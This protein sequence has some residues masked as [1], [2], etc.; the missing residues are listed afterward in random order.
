MIKQYA[1]S[2][3]WDWRLLAS[4]IYQESGFKPRQQSWA[5]AKGLMQVMPATAGQFGIKDL[6]NPESS[7]KAGTRYLNY[8]KDRWS[9]IPDSVERTKF[10]MASYNAGPNHIR[11]AQRLAEKNNQDTNQWDVV[12][13][14]VLKLDNPDVYNDPVVKY[15]YCRG[16]EPYYYV[17]EILQRYNHYKKFTPEQTS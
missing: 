1:D 6:Y 5:G 17:K 13:E 3:Q 7:V 2:I 10:I 16:E 14:F 4:L 15:G 12:S 9:E 11:D 8:L